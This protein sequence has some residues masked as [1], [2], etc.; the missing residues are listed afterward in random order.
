MSRWR[1]PSECRY[2]RPSRI[3][4]VKNLMTLSSN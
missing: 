3:C 2:S 4:S 1:M